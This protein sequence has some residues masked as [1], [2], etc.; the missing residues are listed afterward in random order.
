MGSPPDSEAEDDYGDDEDFNEEP[1]KMT[2]EDNATDKEQPSKMT[3]D[4]NFEDQYEDDE[5]EQEDAGPAPASPAKPQPAE[6]AN[7]DL[8]EDDYDEY[9]GDN[10][11]FNTTGYTQDETYGDEEEEAYEKDAG[12]EVAA[13]RDDED[14]FIFDDNGDGDQGDDESFGKPEAAS[15]DD[16]P[17]AKSLPPRVAVT[18][19]P[20][21]VQKK[22][23]PFMN[24]DIQDILKA[25]KAGEYS[26]AT[27]LSRSYA[28]KAKTE[29]EALLEEDAEGRSRPPSGTSDVDGG[30]NW[31][32]AMDKLAAAHE[33]HD[34]PDRAEALYM[35]MLAWREGAE[36]FDS[37]SFQVSRLLFEKSPSYRSVEDSS[38][39][40]QNLKPG[41]GHSAPEAVALLALGEEVAAKAAVA[42][43]TLALRQD[44]REILTKAGALELVAKAVA[45]HAENAELQAAGC[46]ALRLLCTGHKLAAKNRTMLLD[47]LGGSE[48]LATAIRTHREDEEVQREA[49]GALRA[50]AHKNPSG[51][52]KIVDNDGFEVC[53]EAIE[54]SWDER[55]GEAAC[56]AIAAMQCASQP[57]NRTSDAAAENLEAVWEGRLRSER[58]VGIH[59]ADIKL[60]EHLETGNRIV[61]QALLAVVNIFVEDTSV[62]Q[63]AIS[64]IE[65]VIWCMQSFPSF[66]KI[67]VPAISIL[68]RLTVGHLAREEAVMKVAA[69]GGLGPICQ[70][71]RDLP[72][73]L[74]LQRLAVGVLRNTT[75]ANDPNK[76]LA[77][78]GQAIPA[79]L[80]AMQRFPKDAM[81]QEQAIGA[82]TSL[83]DT[84]GRAAVC[85]RLGGVEAIVAAIRRHS[86]SG[87]VAELGCI[88]LCM[89]SDDVQ[90][91]QH[92]VKAGSM[93]VAKSLSRSGQPESQRWGHELLRALSEP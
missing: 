54:T 22:T 83:G 73:N 6:E 37:G 62:R 82:M 17:Q 85:A 87:H 70:A 9:G 8:N 72:C 1:S 5:D 92:C 7:H 38:W 64:C 84:L 58:E 4:D 63:R 86:S 16:E 52:R 56:K 40:L 31:R 14:G 2:D 3:D 13:G 35:R 69:F 89:L 57:T 10:T 25:F 42:V 30:S 49:C 67:Q 12:A 36:Q 28:A 32:T 20:A 78:R 48:S 47:S 11:G 81:L 66:D 53:L 88:F 91:R 45:F 27:S 19:A 90:M 33:E 55:V 76:T 79:V 60:R 18:P 74:E 29:A 43:Y 15:E 77:V 93:A 71:M 21:P 46:G 23:E 24:P 59:F 44:Q 68:Q 50:A 61:V 80:S 39:F 65:P 75:F 51:A 41:D 26:T 34:D